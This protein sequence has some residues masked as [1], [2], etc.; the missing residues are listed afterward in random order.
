MDWKEALE[1][2]VVRTG[3]ELYREKCDE[4]NPGHMKWRA[5]MV[6]M[7]GNFPKP[8]L[9]EQAVS[10]GKAVVGHAVDGFRNVSDEVY[11][12]RMEI[13]ESCEHFTE[14]KTCKL[15]TCH[16]QTKCQWAS[17]ECPIKKWLRV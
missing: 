4:S 13:C 8:N 2:N 7:A 1:I 12:E 14:Q 5:E 17:S 6:R 9:I 3:H 16:M 10:L 11:N 15:C